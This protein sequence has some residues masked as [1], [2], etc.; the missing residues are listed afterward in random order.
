LTSEA[1]TGYFFLVAAIAARSKLHRALVLKIENKSCNMFTGIVEE[2]GLVVAYD[3][4]ASVPMWDGST[5]TGVLLSVAASA[6]LQGAYIGA[7]I[8]VNGVCLTIT[9]FDAAVFSFGVST[10][11]YALVYSMNCCQ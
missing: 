2:M 5:G 1:Q 4:S 10:E 6:T 8:A 3:E 9:A 11:T 7:S